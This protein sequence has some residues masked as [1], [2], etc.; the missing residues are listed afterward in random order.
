MPRNPANE[1][2]FLRVPT[3]RGNV[4]VVVIRGR[5]D[6]QSTWTKQSRRPVIERKRSLRDRLV[7][8]VQ[9]LVDDR[10]RFGELGFGDAQRRIG[11]EAVPA[12]ERIETFLAEE[13]TERL[14]L[15]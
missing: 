15:R 9:A 4:S 12:H 6:R 13:F 11:E 8:R 14:H 10:E 5:R 2:R 1:M 7:C 3:D